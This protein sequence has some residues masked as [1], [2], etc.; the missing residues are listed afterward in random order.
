MMHRGKKKQY[1]ITLEI[2][3]E[4]LEEWLEAELA[5]TT[6]QSYQLDGKHLTMADLSAI[7]NTIKYWSDKVEELKVQVE[8][9][10]RNRMYRAVPRDY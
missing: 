3:Q 6:H 1:G 5:V 4:H 10:G 8:S 2:A 7:R 9:G